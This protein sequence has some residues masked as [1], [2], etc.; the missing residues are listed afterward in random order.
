MVLGVCACVDDDLGKGGCEGGLDAGAVDDKEV[1]D[2]G[3]GWGD[4]W[5]GGWD[6]QGSFG[7]LDVDEGDGG[8]VVCAEDLDLNIYGDVVRGDLDEDA[9]V[10]GNGVVVVAGDGKVETRVC[11]DGVD[12]IDFEGA[13]EIL[14]VE[15]L[16]G[17][18]A[19]GGE[20][21]V[22]DVGVVSCAVVIDEAAG[23]G[24]LLAHEDVDDEDA[25][26]DARG[27]LV[28]DDDLDPLGV[29]RGEVCCD[30]A[31]GG[32]GAE[33]DDGVLIVADVGGEDGG[34]GRGDRDAVYE[35]GAGARG[36]RGEGDGVGDCCEKGR[37]GEEDVL[38]DGGLVA[39][40]DGALHVEEGRGEGDFDDQAGD[41]G[42]GAL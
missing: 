4:W 6:C 28:C 39:E 17:V 9:S 11:R 21:V 32:D 18:L 26:V 31:V 3:R 24:E 5:G 12:E 15:G 33:L 2:C 16:D 38:G 42:E 29:R 14:R 13:C 1:R 19:L 30:G 37:G 27:E 7:E 10:W 34:G 35:D 20:T 41:A 23:D 22:E 25:L 36:A 8:D 40:A